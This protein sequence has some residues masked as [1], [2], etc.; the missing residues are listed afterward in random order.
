MLVAM[1]FMLLIAA[2]NLRGVGGS[3]RTNVVLTLVELT[4]LLLVI[5]S[6]SG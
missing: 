4:G 5:L 2:I 1:G 3:V 6:G